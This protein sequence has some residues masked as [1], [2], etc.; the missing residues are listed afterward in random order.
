MQVAFPVMCAVSGVLAINA[1]GAQGLN[2]AGQPATTGVGCLSVPAPPLPRSPIA[3]FRELLALSPDDREKT[4][5]EKSEAQRKS[6]RAKLQEYV[7][8]KPEEREARLQATELRWHIRPLMELPPTNRPPLLSAVPADLRSL[9]EARLQE[10]DGLRP[11]VQKLVLENERFIR[12][13]ERLESRPVD[14]DTTPGEAPSKRR[15]ELENALVRWQTLPVPQRQRMCEHFQRFFELA[16]DAK[17]RTLSALSEGERR[18]MEET[19]QVFE[20]LP[21]AQRRLCISSFRKLAGMGPEERARFLKNA[22]Q[23]KEMSPAERQTWRTV[24]AQLPPSP[25]GVAGP[26]LPPRLPAPKASTSAPPASSVLLTN[27]GH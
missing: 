10:W 22:E 11:E 16:P 17:A 6:L 13:F 4:L 23:W 2:G 25:P 20:K 14:R 9:V 1:T 19:L 24:V 5:L 26:P 27:V 15:E 3:Y 7:A 21:P 12:I 18:Q 8:L